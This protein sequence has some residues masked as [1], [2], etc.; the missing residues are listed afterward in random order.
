MPERVPSVPCTPSVSIIVPIYNVERYL[1]GC[2]DGILAQTLA[3]I[4]VIC[5]NDGSTDGSGDILE[6][7]A[8]RDDRITVLDGPNGGYGRAVNRGIDAAHG[9]YVG[10]VVSQEQRLQVARFRMEASDFR[11]FVMS[12]DSSRRFAH[13]ALMDQVNLCNRV[14]EKIGVS[15]IAPDVTE[16][17]R[18]TYGAF[19]MRVVE[20]YYDGNSE[21][22]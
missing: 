20:E 2:L 13:N 19:A 10:I 11:E 21:K 15:A 22:A 8:H 9:E 14:C 7:Y 17:D 16:S 3:N 5:V 18:E 12:V 6:R 1:P 4:E